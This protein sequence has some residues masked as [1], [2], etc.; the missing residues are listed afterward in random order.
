MNH[1]LPSQICGGPEAS[2]LLSSA[3]E[4]EQAVK[5]LENLPEHIKV[6]L[7]EEQAETFDQ[8]RVHQEEVENEARKLPTAC[9]E[10][11][12]RLISLAQGQRVL[13]KQAQLVAI[14][15]LGCV[16]TPRAYAALMEGLLSEAPEIIHSAE[17][18]FYGAD[19]SAMVYLEK[20]FTNRQAAIRIRAIRATLQLLAFWNRQDSDTA[21][22]IHALLEPSL[23]T[24]LSDPDNRA[25]A[26]ALSLLPIKRP[27]TLTYLRELG[28]SEPENSL[29][30]AE[31]RRLLNRT[32][33]V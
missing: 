16:H 17:T 27:R 18:A 9:K 7:K 29:V 28:E 12:E 32:T 5:M 30:G 22:T 6:I 20:F 13:V 31:A 2:D 3:L 33:H 21:D 15:I 1:K 8:T 11:Y 26:L 4:D 19:P 25:R 24:L 10:S 23:P 14:E